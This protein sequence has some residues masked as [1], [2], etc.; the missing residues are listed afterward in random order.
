L[1]VS[2]AN[3]R[4]GEHAI[5]GGYVMREVNF[6]TVTE[7]WSLPIPFAEDGIPTGWQVAINDGG[8]KKRITAYVICVP[9]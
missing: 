3:C 6:A 2:D 9:D 5:S 7:Q 4:P 8:P 1:R